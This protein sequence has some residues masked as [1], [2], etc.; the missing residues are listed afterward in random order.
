[1]L[2]TTLPLLM[3]A[4][5]PNF[6]AHLF[7]Q[8]KNSFT[9][10]AEI[11]QAF[12]DFIA[13]RTYGIN[14]VTNPGDRTLQFHTCKGLPWL[15]SGQDSE[16]S[17]PM[18]Q[19]QPLVV[20]L[21]VHMAKKKITYKVYFLFFG[22]TTQPVGSYFPNQGSLHC[23]CGVLTIGP[24]EKSPKYILMINSIYNYCQSTFQE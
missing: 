21:T 20:E 6:N 8:N 7:I 14:F 4:F 17:L 12:V 9:W 13:E 22:H 23:N 5:Q 2:I 24:P 3:W 11:E 1:M 16:L 18:A 10:K 19:V 15:S